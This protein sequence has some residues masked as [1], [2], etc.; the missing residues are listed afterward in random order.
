MPSE[1][2]I[3][4][5]G[6]FQSETGVGQS[7]RAA[8]I[9]LQTTELPLSLRCVGDTGPSRKQDYSAGPG[10]SS[11][12]YTTNLFYVN[13]D[14]THV[15]RKEVG[16]SFYRDR[17]NIGYWVWELDEF[18]E[19]W[20]DAFAPY[21]EIWTPS[22]F[23]RDAVARKASIPVFCVPYSVSP[24]APAGMG[25]QH[26]GLPANRFIFMTAFDVLSVIERKNPVAVIRAFEK[27]FGPD[28]GC[29]LLIKVNHA[30][31]N[32]ECIQ[33]LRQACSNGS[34]RILDST[35][36]R[37]EMDALT[38]CAD[39]I[40]S[41][42]RS[43]G[44]GLLIAEAMHFGKPVVV[45]N[46]S[47]NTDFTRP[48]NSLLVDY[49]MV[50]VGPHCAPYDPSSYWADPAVEHAASHLRAIA[51]QQELRC[52]LAHAGQTLVRQMLCPEVVGAAMQERME[53][54]QCAA[55]VGSHT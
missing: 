54:L 26:F 39:C 35:L 21:Q 18:P 50:P 24:S 19:Q 1:P 15:I 38:N 8:R 34:V 48:D 42:H 37:E 7:V 25:R 6:Y 40:V 36:R 28:S 10:S 47:G 49:R 44:F 16:D 2:G 27:A 31:A 51:S 55:A 22:T 13:A 23:C 14:Q 12:P 5:V 33:T 3:N 17:H 53:H 11:F 30:N 46:Y 41:L 4:L 32:P 43:E 20:L 29:E 9:A 52:R 45:T